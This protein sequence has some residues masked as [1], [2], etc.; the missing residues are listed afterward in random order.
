[1]RLILTHEQADFDAVAAL[2]A[3]YLL[4]EGAYAVL[5]R[6]LNRNV[7]SF[8]T[9]YGTEFPFLESRDLPPG[10]VE[11]VTLVDT[12]SLITLKG[13]G[14]RTRVRV[15]DHHPLRKNNPP[16]W[17]ITTFD[18]GATTT[19][20]TEALHEQGLKLTQIQATLLLL[21]IYEDTGSL[22]YSRTTARDAHAAAWLLEQGADLGIASR[23]LNPP[24]TPEQR[25]VYERLVS[26]AEIYEINGHRLIVTCGEA[27]NLT[28]EISS[29]AHKLRDLFE[30]DAL[31]VLVETLE[32][33]RL[34]ARSTTDDIDVAAIA[35]QF[36]GGGH[37]RAAAA[38]IK[39]DTAHA[40]LSISALRAQLLELLP[41]YVRPPIS[42]AQVMSR[43]P[44]LLAPETPAQEAAQLMTRY[45]YEGFP[46]AKDGKIIGLLTRRA[47]D[48][49]LNHRL[50]L[51]AA[52]LMEAGE[53]TV[54]PSDSLQR[55]QSLMI[56]SGWGQ[57]PVVEPESGKII[58]IVTRTDL[59][60]TLVRRPRLPQHTYA[61]QLERSLPPDRL[62]VLRAIA[63]EADRQH[64]PAYIVGGF[65]RD[66]LLNRPSLDF[67]IVVEGDAIL[68][69]KALAR[70]YGGRVT[71]HSRFGTAKWNLEHSSFHTLHS[72]LDLISSRQEFYEHP[73]ALPT[74]E[75]GSIKL[76]L[77]RRD[78]TINTLALRLDGR[79]FGELHD[80]YGGLTDLQKGCVRV[81]HSLSFIDDPTRMLRAVRYEQRYGFRI[82]PRTLQLMDEAKPLIARLSHERVRHEIDLIVEEANAPAMLARLAE[83][84]L[85]TSITDVLIWNQ[86]LRQRLEAA[87]TTPPPPEWRL[88]ATLAGL[89][90]QGALTYL[91]WLLDLP[92]PNLER[93]Q[94]RL[95]FPL[96][97]YKAL[98]AASSLQARLPALREKSPSGWVQQLEDIP[99]P[100]I[101]AVFQVNQEP[102]L[103]EYVLHWQTIRPRT[104]GQTLKA[105]GLPPGPA[106]QR[107]LW[108]LRA[109]W[110]DGKITNEAQETHLLRNLLEQGYG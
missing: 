27:H 55:V 68:L 36:G 14:E 53:V 45:G 65:V 7:R 72:S 32:G 41:R 64:L 108:E 104:N 40:S 51:P 12:Q 109:A 43:R 70:K 110:L 60:K 28:E 39:K 58:G 76:D 80:Y 71:S 101:Y 84:N 34:V 56:E 13:M 6:R 24:L 57:I 67:D 107:I 78:F 85:M 92:Q 22:T 37:D 82:E 33:I 23:F 91:L 4:D 63:E 52:S 10:A 15:F 30:P 54:S 18:L 96:E 106:Y 46:V 97:L 26:A 77:H 19:F 16:E 61:R 83:L 105:L 42:V 50:N 31:L 81:L 99:L 95:R 25:E 62:A 73:T 74:V 59:L 8:L 75:R 17:E 29:L 47:V 87:R 79:H 1:M 102:A 88:P 100:A 38:L 66:L 11:I 21:G 35:A 48:R 93:L 86:T 89:S 103:T 94:E 3:A 5:P 9:L 44:R 20:L 2:Y 49:A 98:R 69:A 90:L